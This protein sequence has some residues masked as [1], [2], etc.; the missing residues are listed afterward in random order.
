MRNSMYHY[1]FLFSCLAALTCAGLVALWPVRALA[2]EG[3]NVSTYYQGSSEVPYGYSD[4]EWYDASDWFDDDEFDYDYDTV[5]YD[6]YDYGSG[7]HERDNFPYRNEYS[8]RYGVTGYGDTYGSYY[9]SD[10]WDDDSDF[11]TWYDD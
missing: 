11:N 7:Y 1:R 10:W 2:E 8:S 3:D 6:Q 4:E 9:T 5:G